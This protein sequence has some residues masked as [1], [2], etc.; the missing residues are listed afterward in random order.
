MLF[1]YIDDFKL[2]SKDVVLL[3]GSYL[4]TLYTWKP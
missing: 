1:S 2:P 4:V 3:L